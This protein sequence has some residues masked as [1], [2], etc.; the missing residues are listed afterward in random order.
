MR[1]VTLAE[2]ETDLQNLADQV[3]SDRF[4]EAKRL[5]MDKVA[6]VDEKGQPLS[7]DD[8]EIV[9]MP[10]AADDEEEKAMD[11]EEDKMKEDEDKAAEEDEDKKGHK[12]AKLPNRKSVR[13]SAKLMAPAVNRPKVWS[14]IKNFTDDSNGEAVD[15]ALRF[16][17]WLMAGA[18]LRKSLNWCDR[19]G[20]EVKAHTEGINSAGGF[21]V[22]DEFETELI[23][24]R[25]QFGVFRREARVRPM[26]S[27]TLRVPRRSATLSASFVG[28]A[29]AGTESTMTFEQVNLI[30]KKAM[31]LTTVSNELAED[32]F[33]NLADDVAGEIAYAF[34]K[35]EDECGFIGDGSSTY[36][37]IRGV[38]PTLEAGTNNVTFSTTTAGRDDATDLTLAEVSAFM[39][40][41]PQF[42]DTPNAKL[43]MH[44]GT[45]HSGFE[46][47]QAAAG[48]TAGRDLGT[49]FGEPSFLGYPVVFSQVMPNM[50]TSAGLSADGVV[51]V[52]GD[53]SLAASFGDRRQTTLQISEHATVGGGSVFEQD[54]LAVR[55]TERFDINVHDTGSSS[56]SGPIVGLKFDI[57][58]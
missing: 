26:A 57:A 27:D 54:E 38:I 17:H 47:L 10:K 51:A 1:I 50:A 21:L 45:W 23:S 55:G 43:Y 34:A 4:I 9:L 33:V 6:V 40:L 12:M 32:A 35:K 16:G 15:K 42:A 53:L 19:N 39:A 30:A 14:R 29:A 36:G 28:E 5:Y 11:D 22:P 37:G 20:I 8:V 7:A 58:S 24:L 18:G 44:K 2:V 25:E 13:T 46:R 41:L 49:G 31:V 56:E 48:G 52:F 3:G